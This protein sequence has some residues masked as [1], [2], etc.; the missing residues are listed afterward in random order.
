MWMKT[1]LVSLLLLAPLLA[2]ASETPEPKEGSPHVE[3]LATATFA[4]GCF[5]CMEHP[6]DELPGVL[7]VTAGYTGGHTE[8]P[9]YEEVSSGGTGHAESVQISY[10]PSKISYGK[11][12]TV[13]WHNVDPTDSGGQ[14]CDRGDQ[15][16]SEIFYHGEEQRRVA[17][18]S[19]RALEK[20]KPFPGKI[21]TKIVPAGPFYPAETYH[22]HYY[23][24]NPVRY[25]YYRFACGRDARLRELW[26]TK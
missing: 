5:W 1:I 25:R 15:Y 19:L 8:N 16:R 6:F 10:N 3:N 14:F 17:E 4:G 22:Q 24:K 20:E 9:T 18:E 23:K 7:S 2:T 26:G 11:L 13:F 21:V 12:L